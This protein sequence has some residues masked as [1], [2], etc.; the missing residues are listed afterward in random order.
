LYDLVERYKVGR[1]SVDDADSER[2]STVSSVEIEQQI[3]QRIRDNLLLT[4]NETAQEMSISR[5]K[6]RYK[7]DLKLTRKHII[8]ID[9][10]EFG[11]LEQMH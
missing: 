1:T 8:I 5:G 9:S 10:G 6:K 7:N 4:V 3:D 2:S 11:L